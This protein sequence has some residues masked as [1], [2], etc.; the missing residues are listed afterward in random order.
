MWLYK[1]RY[2]R[3]I[4]F[5]LL[6]LLL[7]LYFSGIIVLRNGKIVWKHR[8]YCWYFRLNQKY[9]G[10]PYR[11]YIKT[12]R[13]GSFCEELLSENDFEVALTTFC[14]YDHGANASET[15]QKIATD[16]KRVSQMFLV[17]Y[18]L[19]NSQNTYQSITVKK[20]WLLGHLRR[21]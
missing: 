18:N 5:F 19:L 8:P 4:I 6:L 2:V 1:R 14:C 11:A 13:N 16:Q 21:S 15:V 12:A 10:L 3:R 20:F 7:L 9:L 17:C